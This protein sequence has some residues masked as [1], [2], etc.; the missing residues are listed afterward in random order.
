MSAS[1]GFLRSIP[2]GGIRSALT[3]GNTIGGSIREPEPRADGYR[4]IDTPAMIEKLKELNLN[5]YFYGVWDSPTDWDDLKS[6]FLPAAAE[7]G[8]QVW[9]YLVP[10][11]ETDLEGRASRPYLMDYVAWAKAVA[12]LSLEY[13]NLTAWSIDDFEFDVNAKLF[14][15]EYMSEIKRVQNEINPNLGF[16]TCA[17]YGAATSDAFLDRY[18]EFVDGIVYPFLDGANLNTAVASTTG[19]CLDEILEKA[20]PRGIGVV[21][22]VY[23]GRFLDSPIPPRADYVAEVID[24]GRQYADR[25]E[26]IGTVAYGTQVDGAPSPSSDN[27]ALY[28]NGRLSLVSSV[29]RV[30]AGAWAEAS[31]VVKVDPESPRYELSFWHSR[32]FLGRSTGDADDFTLNVLVDGEVVWSGD[33]FEDTWL[34]LWIQGKGLQGPV[35]LTAALRGKSEA[36][37]TFRLTAERDVKGF[38]LDVGVDH[39]ES[40]GFEV[41]DPGFES[42][43]SWQVATSGGPVIG[44]VDV[45]VPDRPTRIFDAVGRAFA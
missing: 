15:H 33:A 23:A 26:L 31:Q 11:S 32:T 5:H 38:T 20:K 45:F 36:T 13:P 2:A 4:H 8:I 6:E 43:A 21:L 12:E 3:G 16:L 42:P 10:P 44:E 14:T 35:D 40:I 9:P 1:E 30:P 7:A 25:G 22:L 19:R 18:G 27:R 28:G 37:L 24:A 41:G 34:S 17:Y 29:V 39:L